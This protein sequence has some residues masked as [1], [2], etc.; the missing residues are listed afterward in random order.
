MK[1]KCLGRSF[2]TTTITTATTTAEEQKNPVSLKTYR[3]SS[4]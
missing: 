1:Q 3:Q 2:E 4:C